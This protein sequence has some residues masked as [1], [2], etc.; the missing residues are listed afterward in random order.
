MMNQRNAQDNN[1]QR[2]VKMEW[3]NKELKIMKNNDVWGSVQ[4]PLEYEDDVIYVGVQSSY[5]PPEK[6]NQD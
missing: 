5:D 3:M 2:M 6:I 1:P 4:A